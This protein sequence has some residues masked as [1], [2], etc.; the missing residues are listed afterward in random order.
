MNAN[1]F[2][3]FADELG[4]FLH[5]VDVLE[6]LHFAVQNLEPQS[7]PDFARDADIVDSPAD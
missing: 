2:F 3:L 1:L 7:C 6:K 4:L 5:E